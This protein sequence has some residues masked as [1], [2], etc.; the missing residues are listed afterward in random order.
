MSWVSLKVGPAG[1]GPS[2][3]GYD[4]SRRCRGRMRVY[5]TR[6]PW[7]SVCVA[8]TW[9][10]WPGHWVKSAVP[11]ISQ[12]ASA[13][14][15]FRATSCFALEPHHELFLVALEADAVARDLLNLEITGLGE[16]VRAEVAG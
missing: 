7:N 13:L 15:R 1:A 10:T 5:G 16:V 6:F 14:M 11:V 12:M 2:G 4:A 8:Y 3:L 9:T